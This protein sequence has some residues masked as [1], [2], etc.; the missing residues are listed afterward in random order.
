MVF[1]GLSKDFIHAE[2]TES[3]LNGKVFNDMNVL[4]QAF[5]ILSNE[6]VVDDDPV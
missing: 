4:T 3:F 2:R 6:L 1:G 5:Q